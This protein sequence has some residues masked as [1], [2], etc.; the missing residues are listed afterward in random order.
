MRISIFAKLALTFLVIV[1]GLV[2]FLYVS[3]AKE[4]EQSFA[5]LVEDR[6]D[7][8]T[9]GID[10]EAEILL[11]E[12]ESKLQGMADNF[13]FHNSLVDS[14]GSMSG[15]AELRERVVE[16]RNIADLDYLW[17]ISSDGRL[18]AAGHDPDAWGTDLAGLD[19]TFSDHLSIA[20]SEETVRA[21]GVQ[22]IFAHSYFI[23]EAMLPVTAYDSYL[24]SV[25]LDGILWGAETI[26]VD[27][28]S[29][30]ADL[31]G[32]EIVTIAPGVDP[33]VSWE[34]PS[35]SVDPEILAELER[36]GPE[37]SFDGEIYEISTIPFPRSE[38]DSERITLHLLIP[39]SD[40]LLRR[41]AILGSILIEAIGGGLVAILLA[42]LISK[43]ITWP[44]ERLKTAVAALASGDLSK[45]VEA[46]SRDE[47]EDLVKA[48]NTMA[49][50]LDANTR[51]LVEAEKLSAWRE[52]ARRLAHEIKNPLSP[53]QLSI[54][55]LVRVYKGNPERFEKN[56]TETSETILQE[57]DRLKTLADE[58]SNF[59]RMPKPVLKPNDISELV[60]G[61][62]ALFDAAK[63]GTEIVYSSD[64][65]VPMVMLDRD[66]MGRVFTNLIKN[67]VE[68]MKDR[69]GGI[70]VAVE[71]FTH[72]KQPWV[73]VTIADQGI[74]MKEEELKQSFNPYFTTKKGGSGLGLAIVQSILSEHRGRI[75]LSSRYGV[76]TTVTLE[77]PG[78]GKINK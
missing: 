31:A 22:T 3:S 5:S 50:E 52:V 63:T 76:G 67:A 14:V 25:R 9:R 46:Q 26:D 28:I 43:S 77:L 30:S 24:E 78:A 54:Q 60:R 40:L 12:I 59:A 35:G 13:D 56:L 62:V 11:S 10:R 75:H 45:R 32:A 58:F 4:L 49:D 48:F 21:I 57:V 68:A 64:G 29:R 34:T 61:S 66:A 65:N 53:I 36:G 72:G 19:A 17:L 39:K 1:A 27:F 74:G 7:R 23:A 55:N 33:L 41:R 51:R 6:V 37:I 47:V 18:L 16:L 69:D 20:M 38:Q 15:E 71:N 70:R 44:I 73:R 8:V 2:T 42:F